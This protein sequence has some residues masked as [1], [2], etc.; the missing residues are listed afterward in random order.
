MKITERRIRELISEET[1]RLVELNLEVGPTE[2][3]RAGDLSGRAAREATSH[4]FKVLNTVDQQA[5]AEVERYLR[6]MADYVFSSD[7]QV[8]HAGQLVKKKAPVG[9]DDPTGEYEK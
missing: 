6:K 2:L 9:Q 3:G 7:Q 5:Q 4:F 1:A 8:Q